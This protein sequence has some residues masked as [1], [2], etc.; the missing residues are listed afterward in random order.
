MLDL[1]Q[2]VKDK[3]L[4]TSARK[5]LDALKTGPKTIEEL[6][7]ASGYSNNTVRLSIARLVDLGQARVGS[8]V[9]SGGRGRPAFRF[10]AV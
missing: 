4:P 6:K 10:E 8:T 2:M 5:V 7:Q 1:Q 9:S 3:E